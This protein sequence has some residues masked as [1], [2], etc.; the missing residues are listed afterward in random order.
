MGTLTEEQVV[1]IPALHSEERLGARAADGL[2]RH[3]EG[4][5]APINIVE[6]RLHR[7]VVHVAMHVE[8]LG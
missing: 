5:V 2:R 8:A 7:N 3:E 1:L 6:N 4:F